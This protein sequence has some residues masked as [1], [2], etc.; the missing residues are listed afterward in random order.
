MAKTILFTLERS[1]LNMAGSSKKT[2][3]TLRERVKFFFK[4]NV[5]PIASV[6]AIITFLWVFI[7]PAMSNMI[8]NIVASEIE[9]STDSITEKFDDKLE[10]VKNTINGIDEDVQRIIKDIYSVSISSDVEPMD[11]FVAYA[12]ASYTTL[13]GPI[14]ESGVTYLDSKSEVA[15]SAIADKTYTV[16]QVVN[17]R[18]LL[19]YVEDGQEVYFW[20]ELSEN[21]NWD[22]N[23]IVNIYE[24]DELQMITDAIYDDGDLL[25]C[26]QIFLYTTSN[27]KIDVWGVSKRTAKNGFNSGETTYYVRNENYTKDFELDTA[28]PEDIFSA[29]AFEENLTGRLEGY[30]Y[31]NT[32]NGQFNDDSATAYMVK[33]FDDG[34][35]KTLYMGN[36]RDG[37]FNDD[38]GNAWMIGKAAIGEPYVYYCGP[39]V[40][41]APLP[42]P[43]L[44]DDH[45]TQ[46]RIDEI[47]GN[48]TFNCDLIWENT[49]HSA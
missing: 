34:T 35:I 7:K 9:K 6:I 32:S 48:Y 33:Y 28:Q 29:D 20:G 42:D 22:G 14:K 38:T 10:E 43:D 49:P 25:A 45:I 11:D 2:H 16:E 12:N 23:C 8:Q 1:V 21:G 17:E 46:E 37:Q 15:Y 13:D 5:E 41:G 31:G 47:I 19:P 26:K 4:K 24:N 3:R 39:F 30:Y 36:F 18:L 27:D 44:W 40:N